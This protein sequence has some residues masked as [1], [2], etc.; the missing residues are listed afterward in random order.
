[1]PK[2]QTGWY[3]S[4]LRSTKVHV[5]FDGHPICGAKI[6]IDLDFQWCANGIVID[7]LECSHCERKAK[8]ELCN[9]IKRLNC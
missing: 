8:K 2:Y 6:G 3:G 1:M 5:V 9:E 4:P 7:Y